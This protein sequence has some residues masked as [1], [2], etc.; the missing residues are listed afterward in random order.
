MAVSSGPKIVNTG[1]IF[2]LDEQ[3]QRSWRGK[4]ITNLIGPSYANVFHPSNRPASGAAHANSYTITNEIEPPVPGIDVYKAADTTSD[5]QTIRFSMRL[6]M[7]AA[8][9][10]YDTT[11]TWSFFIYI[12]KEFQNRLTNTSLVQL[13]QNTNGNDWHSTRGYNSTFNFYGAGLIMDSFTTFDVT[14]TDEWQKVSVTFTPLS[15]NIQLAENG[16]NDNNKWA[17]GYHRT[18]ILYGTSNDAIRIPYHFY[19]AGGQVIEGNVD[20]PFAIDSR[21]TTESIVDISR[22][23][24]T[25][26]ANNLSYTDDQSFEFDNSLNSKIQVL[27]NSVLS[28]TEA[29]SSEAWIWADSSQNN[30]YPYIW[31]KSS[32]LLHI[33]QTP[34]FLI[35]SNI[36][37]AEVGGNVLRQ[38]AVSSAIN[39][40]E[41]THI[42][43][44]FYQGIG[45]VYKNGL[46]IKETNFNTSSNIATYSNNFII[47]GNE[48]TT[49]SFNGK[50]KYFRMYNRE[51]TEDE[52]K[53]NF[54]ATRQRFGI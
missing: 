12:P 28:P 32:N 46:K 25:A 19:V 2:A 9:F 7:D 30:L 10:N 6:D 11:Y 50:I 33:T 51:L 8:W 49:R 13:Y 5:N 40:S 24:F 44:T 20:A 48:S 53:N 39:H 47:G 22:N 54:E 18:N 23:N 37:T 42:C 34:P 26:T 3:N 41:W 43:A 52:V 14:K 36:N 15:A 16:G 1:L 17:A 38:V 27:H 45:K 29:I 21:G 4:P 31:S 35:A